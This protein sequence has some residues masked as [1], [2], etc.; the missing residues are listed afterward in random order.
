MK[1]RDGLHQGQTK[2]LQVLQGTSFCGRCDHG[3]QEPK[4]NNDNDILHGLGVNI[5]ET[6]TKPYLLSLDL[7]FSTT[8]SIK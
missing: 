4:K 6:T 2:G 3:K 1:H 5:R 8:K 7:T